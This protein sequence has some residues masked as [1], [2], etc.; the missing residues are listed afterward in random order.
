MIFAVL[1]VGKHLFS[2]RTL[3]RNQWRTLNVMPA[4][5]LYHFFSEELHF[6]HSKHTE[7]RTS[8]YLYITEGYN[9]PYQL[10]FL[11]EGSIYT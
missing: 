2:S 4:R 6:N 5:N 8:G 9:H 7:K 3:G 11:L 1:A 10:L